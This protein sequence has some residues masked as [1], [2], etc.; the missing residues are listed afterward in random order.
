V[1]ILVIEVEDASPG[2]SLTVTVGVS[3]GSLISA[4]CSQGGEERRRFGRA[5]KMEVGQGNDWLGLSE[6]IQYR[7]LG[8]L[9]DRVDFLVLFN[10]WG[11]SLL[12]FCYL[13]CNFI[14]PSQLCLITFCYMHYMHYFL[15]HQCYLPVDVVY[16]PKCHLC[17]LRLLGVNNID[18]LLRGL[19]TISRHSK[20]KLGN[21]LRFQGEHIKEFLVSNV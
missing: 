17:K 9:K 21:L 10:N 11:N 1:L 5:A 15:I 6:G 16:P 8:S 12:N 19:G 20:F 4:W 2:R 18:N 14:K 7:C 13:L 3:R